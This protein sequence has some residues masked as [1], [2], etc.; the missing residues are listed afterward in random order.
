MEEFKAALRACVL[1]ERDTQRHALTQEEL[2]A[3]KRIRDEKYATWDWNYGS[4][5]A[6]GMRL[7][8]KF[9]A[10]LL[11]VYLQAEAGRIKDIR[12]CGDFFGNGEIRALE[13][14]L[15]SVK[16]DSRLEQ[17]LE[18]LNVGYYI[19]GI[20]ADEIAGLLR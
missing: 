10:G 1:E 20:R 14:R 13:K 11:T 19:N 16:L 6:Y 18:E 3:V 12:F 7:E 5:P 17:T 15:V 2:A 8:R 9:S 4:S